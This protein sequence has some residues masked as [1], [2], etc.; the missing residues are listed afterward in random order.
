MADAIHGSPIRFRSSSSGPAWRP[1]LAL[2][3]A[4]AILAL[5]LPAPRSGDAFARGASG[6]GSGAMEPGEGAGDPAPVG[7]WDWDR[8]DSRRWW[9]RLVLRFKG[10]EPRTTYDVRDRTYGVLLTQVRT[11][12]R[13]RARVRLYGERYE[14]DFTGRTVA[15]CD[16]G[17]ED[18]ILRIRME[19]YEGAVPDEG[20]RRVPYRAVEYDILP[21]IDASLRF[22]SSRS[23]VDGSRRDSIWAPIDGDAVVAPVTLWIEDAGGVMVQVGEFEPAVYGYEGYGYEWEGGYGQSNPLPLDAANLE[24]L[25]GRAIAIRNGTGEDVLATTVPELLGGLSGYEMPEP[26]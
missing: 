2:L 17:A 11:N 20:L 7:T 15:L 16:A 5:L 1:A 6:M 3:C 10:L 25:L 4:G 21:G 19:G 14:T 12:R 22:G 13:G 23:V 24:E 9:E 8:G 26:E 18:P